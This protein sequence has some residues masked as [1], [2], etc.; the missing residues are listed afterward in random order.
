VF[1]E[2]VIVIFV[3]KTFYMIFSV[4]VNEKIHSAAMEETGALAARKR[5]AV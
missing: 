3:A 4:T 5:P 1:K 2:P